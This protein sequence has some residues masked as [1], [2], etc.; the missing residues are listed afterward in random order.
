VIHY[1]ETLQ[2]LDFCISALYY[3]QKRAGFSFP[4][5]LPRVN[6]RLKVPKVT[7][8]SKLFLVEPLYCFFGIHP[9]AGRDK[10]VSLTVYDGA[11]GIGGNKLYLEENGNGVFLDFGKNFGKYGVF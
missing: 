6:A 3:W 1:Y 4:R 10:V 11:Y 5:T 2:P 9:L 7:R 8:L